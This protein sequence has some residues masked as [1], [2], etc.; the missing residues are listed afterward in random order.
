VS[1][2]HP[3]SGA[4]SDLGPT[5][6]RAK[7]QRLLAQA[8]AD[9]G[10][11][12]GQLDAR[13][14]LCAV[15]ATDHAGLIRDPDLPIGSAAASLV[16][17]AERRLHHEPVSRILGRQDFWG[18]PFVITPEVLDPRPDTEAVVEAV[19]Q[20]L[21]DRRFGP[22]RVLDLGTGS[23]ALLCALLQDCPQAYGVGLDRSLAACRV[24]RINLHRLGFASR[25][26]IV[27]GSWSDSLAGPF[28]IVVANPPYITHAEFAELAPAVAAY[29]PPAALDGGQDGLD[30]YRAII[31]Q[32]PRLLHHDGIAAFEVGW[33][34]SDAV[35]VMLRAAGLADVGARRDM[36]GH[37]RV[38]FGRNPHRSV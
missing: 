27:Q 36:A 23:G 35:R 24:A 4:L 31:P 21:G 38:V 1:P 19:L 3:T 2:N 30:P 34:Q 37:D 22:L 33:T 6:T 17:D 15:L 26:A 14:L 18:L 16:A 29:D 8:F 12:T 13:I 11:E 9:V 7:A 25:G 20:A 28:D 5:T 10:I 32:L